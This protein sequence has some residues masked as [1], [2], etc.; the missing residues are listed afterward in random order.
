VPKQPHIRRQLLPVAVPAWIVAGTPGTVLTAAA[1]LPL[2]VT[3]AVAVS[4]MLAAPSQAQEHG[5][6]ERREYDH[7]CLHMSHIRLLA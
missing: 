2:V 5:Q 4:V 7:G 6:D 3:M 1:F